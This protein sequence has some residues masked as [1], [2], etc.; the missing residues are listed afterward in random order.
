MAERC[1]FPPVRR[2][3]RQRLAAPALPD[4]FQPRGAAD[5]A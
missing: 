1:L 2:F 3:T 4:G 5:P